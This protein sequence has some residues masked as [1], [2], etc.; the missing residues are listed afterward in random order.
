MEMLID[1]TRSI[2]YGLKEFS[3]VLAQPC[4]PYKSPGLTSRWNSRL[5]R[6]SQGNSQSTHVHSLRQQTQP[7]RLFFQCPNNRYL[8]FNLSLPFR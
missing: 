4:Q 2:E 5:A 6:V 3:A 1:F 7:E 8:N